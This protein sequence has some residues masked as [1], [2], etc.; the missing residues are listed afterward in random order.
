MR[1][2]GKAETKFDVLPVVAKPIHGFA[3]NQT[4]ENTLASY[5]IEHKATPAELSLLKQNI[6]VRISGV[7]YNKIIN[8]HGT[9]LC[10]PTEA[11]WCRIEDRLHTVDKVRLCSTSEIPA[12]VDHTTEPW[13]PP[14]G[15]QG[16]QGSCTA[17]AVGYYIKT[18]QEAREHEWDVSGGLSDRIVSPAFVYNLVNGG[19]DG[20]SFPSMAI[21]LICS[22]GACSLE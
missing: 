18:Y 14:I 7:N 5:V 19:E 16:V 8:G 12:S 13:F 17:W 10:P 21:D 11:E 20:G 2:S 15:N 4:K 22:V 9:G 3:S 6:G 1:T